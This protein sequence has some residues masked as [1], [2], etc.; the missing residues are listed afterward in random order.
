MSAG[1]QDLLAP[2]Q[3][4]AP[5][6]GVEPAG[7]R[8]RSISPGFATSDKVFRY[9]TRSVGVLVMALVGSIGLYLGYKAIPTLRHYGLSYFTQLHF[10]PERDRVGIPAF[11]VGSIE[12]AVVAIVLALPVA[13]G[14]ALFIT[15]Y[16]PPRLRSL[17]VAVIDLL[18]AV[19]SIIYAIWGAYLL[20]PHLVFV[21]HWLQTYLGWI[22]VFKV[23]GDPRRAQLAQANYTNSIFIAALIIAAMIVPLACSLMR[24]VFSQTPVGERE[25]ALALGSTRWGVVR[26]VVLPFGRSGIIG[27]TMLSLGRALGET[28]IV[29]LI[30]SSHEQI[31]PRILQ[32]GGDTITSLITSH[33]GDASSSQ[34]SA[35]LAAGFFLFLLTLLINTLAGLVI[36]R[37]RSGAATEL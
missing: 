20:Q 9:S 8:P 24:E 7:D 32:N 33:F 13:L 10:A 30:L 12:V 17:L 15:E 21:A 29:V 4:E 18:S 22:P 36:A 1:L 26:S 2:A 27:G 6:S 3:Q 28:I 5:P 31:S 35:L 11:L 16:A 23:D 25:A 34:L 37:S 14:M 19:P